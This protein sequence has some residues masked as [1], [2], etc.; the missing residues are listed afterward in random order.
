MCLTAL[1]NQ[2]YPQDKYEII[3]VNDGST[4]ETAKIALQY[5]VRLINL[6]SNQGRI[7]SRNTGAKAARYDM[8]VFCDVRVMVKPQLLT[9]LKDR[10]YQPL[11]PGIEVYDGSKWGFERFFHLLRYKIY[12]PYYPTSAWP[13]EYWITTDNFEQVP[14]GTTTFLCDRKLWLESQPEV[15]S[16]ITSDDTRIL[17]TIVKHRPILQATTISVVYKQRTKLKDVLRHT[18][19]R[20]PRFADYYLRPGRRYFGPYL[21]IWLLLILTALAAVFNFYKTVA[22]IGRAGLWGGTLVAFY[23]SRKPADVIVVTLCFPVVMIA[24]SLGILKWQI[25]QLINLFL[26]GSKSVQTEKQHG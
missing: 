23:L 9:K 22:Y 14:K 25:L 17:R 15:K 21:F 7:V 1:V 12:A 6:D 20:G 11:M 13:R 16:K 19:E 18:L 24:F 5:P 3:V 8:L 10:N 2:D 26:A 4:D